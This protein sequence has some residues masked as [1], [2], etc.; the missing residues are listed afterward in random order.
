MKA[1]YAGLDSC[2][3][4]HAFDFLGIVVAWTTGVYSDALAYPNTAGRELQGIIDI[5]LSCPAVY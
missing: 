5:S 1:D 4:P 3:M 2:N